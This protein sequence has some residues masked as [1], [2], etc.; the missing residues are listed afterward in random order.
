MVTT[1]MNTQDLLPEP[2]QSDEL[3]VT[4][5]NTLA[6]TRGVASDLVAEPEALL[7]WLK[8]NGLIS[9]RG[10]AMEAQRLLRDPAEAQRRLDRFRYLRALVHAIAERVNDGHRPTR[11]QI[12]D[13][14]HILR[15][16]LHFHQ[17]VSEA[18]GTRYSVAQVGD[19]LDQARATIASS[20]AN[21]LAQD[22]PH[23]LR[24]CANEGCREVFIDRSPTGRRR[25]CDMRTCGNRAKVARHRSRTR[26]LP[27]RAARH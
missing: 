21:F 2:P 5:A 8:E 13:L 9:E 23:R 4:F 3:F 1:M 15:H 17:L 24:T 19:H 10:R 26:T 22:D 27:A 25:W 12:R 14:N 6:Y 18:Q 11:E 16:G 20:L 7:G